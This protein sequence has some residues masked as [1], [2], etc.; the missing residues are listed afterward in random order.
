MPLRF[1]VAGTQDDVTAVAVVLVRSVVGGSAAAEVLAVG[2]MVVSTGL[3]VDVA[4]GAVVT[5][6]S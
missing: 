6:V 2:G 3:V 4:P 5:L 1:D